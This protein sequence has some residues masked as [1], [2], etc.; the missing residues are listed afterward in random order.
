MIDTGIHATK[1]AQRCLLNLCA[2]ILV[3]VL[4]SEAGTC[5][6]TIQRWLFCCTVMS[7]LY[8]IV[9]INALNKALCCLLV[10]CMYNCRAYPELIVEYRH[11]L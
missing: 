11:Q 6:N 5:S 9:L 7:C 4:C 8:A 10:T 2:S 1:G 3:Y